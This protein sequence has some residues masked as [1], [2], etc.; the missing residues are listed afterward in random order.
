MSDPELML[1][2]EPAAGLDLGGREDLVARLGLLAQTPRRRRWSSS[3][4][5]SR[6]SRRSSPTCCSCAT[7]R[8]VAQGPLELTL[9]AENLSATFGLPLQLE[10]HGDRWS[11][12]AGFDGG[13]SDHGVDVL[14]ARPAPPESERGASWTCSRTTRGWRWLGLALI[15][16]AIEAATVDFVFLMLAG[17]ALAAAV[18]AAARAPLRRARSSSRSS[19]P[20][21]SCCGSRGRGPSAFMGPRPA[22]ASG[23]AASSAAPAACSR[24]SPRTDGRV[25]VGRG[26]LVRREP[27]GGRH[28]PAPGEEVQV[29]IHRRGPP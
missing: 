25:K 1:L 21:C 12:R 6:R 2:D 17:G 7:A 20:G 19:S 27:A 28:V 22:T 11:A 8:V 26:D 14:R 29:V 15:L 18:A 16:G 13:T 4:T 5:T 3:P 9:T 23:P 24:P 10:R